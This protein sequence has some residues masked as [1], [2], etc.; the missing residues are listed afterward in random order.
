LAGFYVI[1]NVREIASNPEN[2][3]FVFFPA[4]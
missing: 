2:K 4:L 3:V 1:G